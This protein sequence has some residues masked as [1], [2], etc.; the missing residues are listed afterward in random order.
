MLCPRCKREITRWEDREHG[1]QAG[2][3]ICSVGPVVNR[4]AQRT[5]TPEDQTGEVPESDTAKA[6]YVRRR[7]KEEA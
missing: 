3:C 5:E 7:H 2:Y 1:R 6:P 4:P